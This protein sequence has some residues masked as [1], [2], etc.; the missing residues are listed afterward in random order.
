MKLKEGSRRNTNLENLDSTG[1]GN[2]V[3]N[4]P[5]VVEEAEMLD[6]DCTSSVTSTNQS[7][8]Q[9]TPIEKE[10]QNKN[11]SIL[12]LFARYKNSH[13]N[14]GSPDQMAVV[15]NGCVSSDT[16]DFSNRVN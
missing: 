4:V 5:P 14:L 11:V 2:A 12:S 13:C 3:E 1:I 16:S 9:P 15:E 7:Y 6:T 10:R 8:C